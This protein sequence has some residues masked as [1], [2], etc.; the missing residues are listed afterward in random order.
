MFITTT[1]DKG[2]PTTFSTYIPPSTVVI[3]KKV[4]SPLP[5]DYLGSKSC[6]MEYC[7]KFFGWNNEFLILYYCL[8]N[9]LNRIDL[10]ISDLMDYMVVI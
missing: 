10:I 1:N 6:N 8:I 7:I 9:V 4:T 2:E 5:P 3:V